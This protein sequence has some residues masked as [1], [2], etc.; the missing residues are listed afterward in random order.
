VYSNDEMG[1]L[2][3][4]GGN[5]SV[6]N[7]IVHSHSTAGIILDS[8]D[9]VYVRGNSVFSNNYGICWT[10]DA[11]ENFIIENNIASNEWGLIWYSILGINNYIYH[12]T[13]ENNAITH[14]MWYGDTLDQSGQNF[15]NDLYPSGG[16]Y[17]S[18]Y[19]GTDNNNDG[20]G[21]TPYTIDSNNIDYYPLMSPYK[22]TTNEFLSMDII[23]NSTITA[24]AFD[25]SNKTVSFNV[26]GQSGTSGFTMIVIPKTLL[27]SPEDFSILLDNKCVD[28]VIKSVGDRWFLLIDYSHSVHDIVLTLGVSVIPEFCTTLIYALIV[29]L[30]S[31]ITAC[32]TIAKYS[33]SHFF[34]GK[35]AY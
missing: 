21:D 19:N 6:R 34:N 35:I 12:N 30:I 18:N 10:N 22:P 7:N 2:I 28:Y 14:E 25:T 11:Q 9:G 26:Q 17:W 5:M 4:G 1:I 3:H 13:L 31:I 27:S 20:L 24:L 15:W 33:R 32:L 8:C 29:T 23:S 16:N